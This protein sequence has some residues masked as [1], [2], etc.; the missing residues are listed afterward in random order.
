MKN[1]YGQTVVF[2]RTGYVLTWAEQNELA[3]LT[4]GT[5]MNNKMAQHLIQEHGILDDE[6]FWFATHR[7][8]DGHP[9]KRDWVN[10]ND[11]PDWGFATSYISRKDYPTHWEAGD[12]QTYICFIVGN[13]VNCWQDVMDKIGDAIKNA[14]KE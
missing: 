12:G 2:G 7:I 4:G 8:P 9:E 13:K 3:K 5:L 11:D 10:T 1:S 14:S 6:L